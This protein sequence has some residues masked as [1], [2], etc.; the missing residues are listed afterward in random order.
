L[1]TIQLDDVPD[2]PDP[3]STGHTPTPEEK[4]EFAERLREAVAEETRIP[5]RKYLNQNVIWSPQE[6]SQDRFM[7]CPFF[8][9]LYHGTRGP[10]KTDAL[11]M[12]FAQHVGKGHG[13]AWRGIIFRQTYPQL[14]DVQAK[15]EKWF[16]Q[17]FGSRAKFNRSKMMWEW[18]TGEVLLLRHMARPSDY[19]NYHGHEYPFIGFEELC[20][21]PDDQCYTSMF[22]CC[23]SSTMGVPRMVRATTNPYGPGHNW[24][25]ARWRLARR[26]WKPFIAITDAVD[27]DGRSE[28]A[29]AAYHGHIR[30]NKI[31]LAA[32][33]NYVQV[34]V[35]AANN[36]AMKEA[37]LLGSWDIVAGGM[38]D[39]VWSELYNVVPE[40][41]IPRGWRIDRSFDWGSSAPFS[42]GWWA[43][44]DGSDLKL[45]NGR[46]RS[47]VKGDL[48][49]VHEWYG[50]TGKPNQGI[51]LLAVDIAEGIVEREM[52]WGYRVGSGAQEKRRVKAGPAD[53]SIHNV[54]NGSCIAMD[55]AKPIR[56]G[57][58]MHRGVSWTRA[59]KSD[60]SVRNGL[61]QMRKMI[62]AAHPNDGRPREKPGLFVTDVCEQFLRTIPGLARDERDMDKIDKNAEDHVCDEVRYRVRFV[63]QKIR[64]G[65]HVGMY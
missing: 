1:S 22:A 39:D 64:G 63:G 17:I 36:P 50:W 25:K 42:V 55:M 31:M 24:V 6:G 26:W 15:S 34:I 11:L 19:W 44:S 18:D 21:W 4:A 61:E 62:K 56:V 5:V 14:A 9:G 54:E 29:R 38:F 23:R 27:V 10:G 59:D 8:E 49:R 47:T 20:N 33:P 12:A 37:W 41:D 52:E 28:P 60:G 65:R 48:F 3:Q 13:A 53:N 7:K 30:E 45:R 46:T 2:A 40:F 58:E 32:D 57:N 43:E 51:R 16:R 35:A